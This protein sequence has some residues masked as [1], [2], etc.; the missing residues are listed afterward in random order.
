MCAGAAFDCLAVDAALT[1]H[2]CLQSSATCVDLLTRLVY[3][4]AQGS[5]THALVE[6]ADE[7]HIR[8]QVRVAPVA[9]R[10]AA[11]SPLLALVRT[12]CSLTRA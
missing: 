4:D 1:R 2:Y 6:E 9:P 8:L 12:S 11:S 5:I 7:N 3:S 10:R